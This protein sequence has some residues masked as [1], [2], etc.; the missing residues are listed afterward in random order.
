MTKGRWALLGGGVVVVVAVVAA[1]VWVAPWD[2]G[3]GSTKGAGA[4]AKADPAGAADAFAAAWQAGDLSKASFTV[5]AATVVPQAT[6]ITAGLTAAPGDHPATVAITKVTTQPDGPVATTATGPTTSTPGASPAAGDVGHA[7]A[8]ATVTWKLDGGHTWTYRTTIA[9]QRGTAGRDDGTWRVVWSPQVVEPSLKAGEALKAVRTP[10]ARGAITDATGNP[11]VGLKDVVEVGIQPSR[12]TDP[13]GTARTVA[14]LVH[15]DADAL[16]KRVQ[17]APPTQFVSVITLRKADYDLI[18][19]Q[20]QPLPGTVFH[21]DQQTLGPT[22]GFASALLGS[23]GPATAA[24]AAASKGRVVVGD[25]VGL[26]GLQASQDAT[27]AGTPGLT[28]QA[29]SVAPES[30]PRSLTSFPAV[31]GKPVAITLD[32]KV[33]QAADAVMA[34]APKPAALVAIRVST[35]DVLAVSNGPA[36]AA[37]YD[38]ALIGHYPPG[39]TFKVASGLTLLEH[40]GI[41]PDTPV[42]CPPT[43]VVGKSF[44]NAE[45]EQ[46]GTVPFS[47]DFAK[48]C[49]TAFVGSSSKIT[50]QQLTDTAALL[51]YRTLSLG[52]PV[53]GGSVPVTTD[54]TEHA[55]DMIG[56]GKVEASPFAVA[57]ASASVAN[58]HSL[59]PRLIIDPAKPNPVGVALPAAQ[60][61]QLKGLMR[62]VVT[63]GTGTALLG[64]PG[65]D[66][67]G[68]TGTAEFGTDD[69]PQTHAWFTGFQGDIAFAVL[70]EA[71]GFGATAAA[72]LAAAFLTKLA[73]A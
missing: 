58:G 50:S 36:A 39:S 72:P 1:V 29:V 2:G 18:R 59:N 55:A 19:S 69:P 32:T 41:T 3:S 6:L 61:A 11:L 35:G 9:L 62:G 66:V 25:Q 57:L 27:L 12:T 13:A 31:A 43:V 48:S 37:G 33:Q 46:F 56:Q 44:K 34:I 4:V 47:V 17:A 71:G 23:V 26:S 20:I 42:S 51:G 21:E 73:A 67:A 30:A 52:V 7:T 24:I 8:T 68:K 63:S 15:V 53:F 60:V 64:I 70:V 38:R 65:G 45:A 22:K 14:A 54:A 10:A 40:G 5:P 16:V 28:V 49:N